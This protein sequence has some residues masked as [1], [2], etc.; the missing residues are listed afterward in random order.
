MPFWQGKDD[1][2]P[3]HNIQEIAQKEVSSK[4]KIVVAPLKLTVVCMGSV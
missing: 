4:T 1:I 3:L 2:K